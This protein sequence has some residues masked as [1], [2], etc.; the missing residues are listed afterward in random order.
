VPLLGQIPIDPRLREGGDAGQ[1]LVLSDPDTEAS[2]AIRG[3]SDRLTVRSRGLAGR[4]LGLT[5]T[6]K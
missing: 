4:S 3:I 2:K 5:P 6:R 1:P